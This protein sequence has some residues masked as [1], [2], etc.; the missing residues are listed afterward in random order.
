MKIC[1]FYLL[2]DVADDERFQRDGDDLY[3]FLS[4]PVTTVVLGGEVEVPTL[5]GKIKFKVRPGTQ[6]NTLIRLRGKG[7]PHLGQPRRRGDLY[8]R[9]GVTVPTKL[10][11]AEEKLWRQLQKGLTNN[12]S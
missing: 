8:V 7:M 10:S 1:D 9:L 11:S 4:V 5:D 6:P 3:T 12:S 2:V